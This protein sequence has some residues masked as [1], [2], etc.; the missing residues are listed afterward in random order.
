MENVI[1]STQSQLPQCVATIQMPPTTLAAS[2]RNYP[3][4]CQ[5]QAQGQA[6]PSNRS[7]MNV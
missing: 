3:S 4:R 5:A 6:Y 1:E 2:A 7:R